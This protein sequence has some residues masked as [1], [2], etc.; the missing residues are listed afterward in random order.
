M[1]ELQIGMW[2]HRKRPLLTVSNDGE[3]KKYVLAYFVN[4]AA[5][6]KFVELVKAGLVFAAAMEGEK[7]D[8]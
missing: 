6:E 7:S 1:P 3:N 8:T 4:Q 2:P 5:A